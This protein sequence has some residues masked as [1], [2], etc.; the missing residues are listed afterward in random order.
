MMDWALAGIIV[1]IVGTIAL[2]W[3]W[4]QSRPEPPADP[5]QEAR[6]AILEAWTKDHTGPRTE[7][8]PMQLG[9]DVKALYPDQGAQDALL[10]AWNTGKP[11]VWHR[12]VDPEPEAER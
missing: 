2:K 5:D 7:R 1:M 10:E 9:D 8:Q 6:N 4:R 12:P 3:F 11:V